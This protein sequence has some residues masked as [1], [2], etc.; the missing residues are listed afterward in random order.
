MKTTVIIICLVLIYIDIGFIFWN[1]GMKDFGG[2]DEYKR[3]LSEY[4]ES[5][6]REYT[7]MF[8]VANYILFVLF[9]PR[10]VKLRKEDKDEQ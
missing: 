3:W 5:K 2:T 8:F 1:L 6:G 10:F 4:L 7:E 9:W